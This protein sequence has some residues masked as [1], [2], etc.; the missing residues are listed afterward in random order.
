M[1]KIYSSSKK[2][3]LKAVIISV[4]LALLTPVGLIAQDIVP[5][6]RDTI[7]I[8]GFSSEILETSTT[9][10]CVNVELRV[11][12]D[13]RSSYAL[14]HFVVALPCGTVSE[15]YNSRGW[16]MEMNVQDP[17][18]GLSGFK[19]DNI[20][21]FGEDATRDS[22]TV[23]YTVCSP[24]TECLDLVKSN[25]T[26]SYKAGGCTFFDDITD[27][28]DSGNDSGNGDDGSGGDGNVT[29]DSLILILTPG[30]VT[31]Y[32]GSNGTVSS[33]VS[34][35]TPPYAYLWNTGS[36]SASLSNVATGNYSV[37]VTDSN[38]MSIEGSVV[39]EQPE[40]AI[41][42]DASVTNASC[43]AAD[44]SVNVNVNGGQAPYSYIWSNGDTSQDLSNAA[45][46]MYIIT[47]TDAAGCT[48]SKAVKIEENTTLAAQLTPN[49]LECYQE[50]GGKITTGVTGGTAPYEYSWSNGDS[51]QDIDGVNSGLYNLTVTDSEGCS[52][53]KSAY[54]GIRNLSVSVTS[55]S[56]TCSG[57]NDGELTVTNVG[58]GTGPFTYDWNNGDTTNAI[59]GLISGNYIITVTD[60]MGCSATRSVTVTDRPPLSLQYSVAP[61]DC[62]TD[63]TAEVILAGSGGG[64]LFEYYLGDSLISSPITIP[65]DGDYNILMKDQLGCQATN[66]IHIASSE[67]INVVK[68]IT[69]PSC[70]GLKTGYAVIAANGGN[71]PYEYTW[72]DGF[73]GTSHSNLQPGDYT[74]DVTDANGCLSATSFTINGINE[75]IATL[76][77][78][79]QVDCNSDNNV[80]FATATN[81]TDFSWQIES[82][83]NS[84][85][86]SE[87]TMDQALY[88]TGSGTGLFIFNA[89]NDE[90]CE[91]SDSIHLVCT[92]VADSTD[93]TGST[94]DGNGTG[95]D[96]GTDETGGND[97]GGDDGSVDGDCAPVSWVTGITEI[98]PLGNNCYH[99]EMLVKTTEYCEHDL[100]HL[101][102]G[103]DYGYVSDVT[104][105]E[106]F[107]TEVNTTDPKSGVYG[108]KI[109]DISNFCSGAKEM[110]V[111]FNV[112]F[113]NPDDDN[114]LPELI[115]I[116]YK[117]GTCVYE[118]NLDIAM[119][120]NGL[121]GIKVTA[122]PNP[123]LQ[124]MSI[125][126]NSPK[127]TDVEIT[128]FD[129]RGNKIALL[130][131][132]R[133]AADVNYTFPFNASE[134]NG[135]N[136]FIYTV[137]TTDEII[138]GRILKLPE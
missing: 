98:T 117:A 106:H 33:E 132:G 104:N 7:C 137:T 80:V 14:S 17:T 133:L 114:Y 131:K 9:D 86:I 58:Y 126:V 28:D 72:S 108:F 5:L 69:Q 18:T 20:Q 91:A 30:E 73:T 118:Q 121:P 138:Q 128:V 76:E 90:G 35:G 47:V 22:F 24:D 8:N 78:P 63:T 67:N 119:D 120:T 74:V 95:D 130:Y 53:A 125:I 36:T 51:T 61:R 134:A 57:G 102:V 111:D 56:P 46:G 110:I 48:S 41:G 127:D 109:D 70:G 3:V 122:Y 31:C 75:V 6:T 44:G 39:V 1:K 92:T 89:W 42:I 62:S 29:S 68:S 11:F 23:S 45:K 4:L 13:G 26:V 16:R 81:A 82:A 77:P 115:Q 71:T 10:K 97:S 107:K 50:G 25:V 83:D 52:V 87:S 37:T 40:S 21:G 19:V 60:S 85:S 15:A 27:V 79:E 124:E 94:G 84:W 123:F 59:T 93:G 66:V 43:T 136:I 105:S 96:S 12:T 113:Q 99:M 2:Q 88:H 32:N 55:T 49:Y 100:S 135:E 65:G 116:I 34:G 112:C 101:V 64:G 103:L 129:L 38:G 54:I